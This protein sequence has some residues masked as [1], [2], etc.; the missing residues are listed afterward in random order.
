[1]YRPSGTL[2]D[3]Q[4]RIGTWI[5]LRN[6]MPFSVIEGKSKHN[7]E[8]TIG[9]Q[10][11]AY[12]NAP[13]DQ[14][15]FQILNEVANAG[16]DRPAVQEVCSASVTTGSFPG[17]I[18]PAARSVN[19]ANYIVQHLLTLAEVDPVTMKKWVRR[20]DL[21]VFVQGVVGV[22]DSSNSSSNSSST[23][24][25]S[26]CDVEAITADVRARLLTV[27]ETWEPTWSQD[28]SRDAALLLSGGR[29]EGDGSYNLEFQ[30]LLA[31]NV[32]RA[33]TLK[34]LTTFEPSKPACQALVTEAKA[35]VAEAVAFPHDVWEDPARV[36]TA[37]RRGDELTYAAWIACLGNPDA[38]PDTSTTKY[39]TTTNTDPHART[40]TTTA[41]NESDEETEDT[42]EDDVMEVDEQ[43][44]ESVGGAKKRKLSDGSEDEPSNKRR[45]TTEDDE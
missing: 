20:D 36:Q 12:R 35:A 15:R 43:V 26:T 32:E 42:V 4:L 45:R 21:R 7:N 5:A 29:N 23:S 44:E 30:A 19:L 14:V 11:A 33:A 17:V 18:L 38:T 37:V 9:T 41:T 10:L 25:D 6:S 28:E 22:Q 8:R 13:S 27:L 31:W 16:F 3:V 34:Q 2:Q 24:S 39:K 40:T 1:V